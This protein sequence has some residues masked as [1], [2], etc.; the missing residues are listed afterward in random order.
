MIKKENKN[1]REKNVQP[2]KI[3]LRWESNLGN[4]HDRW[5]PRP[6]SYFEAFLHYLDR[7]IKQ[8]LNFTLGFKGRFDLLSMYGAETSL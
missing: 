4:L 8:K 3:H 1:E 2:R 5:A 6:R 7:R